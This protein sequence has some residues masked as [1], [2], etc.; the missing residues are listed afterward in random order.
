MSVDIACMLSEAA[1]ACGAATAGNDK[2]A[3]ISPAA[4]ESAISH[5]NVF[6]G[7]M[8]PFRTSA[9]A[10]QIVDS[11][12]LRQICRGLRG[13]EPSSDSKRTGRLA[14]RNLLHEQPQPASTRPKR[15][16]D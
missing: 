9:A 2:G 14:R 13:A 3:T 8:F 1:A 15:F 10:V 4:T 5:L 12:R 6:R 11:S 7:P 16:P